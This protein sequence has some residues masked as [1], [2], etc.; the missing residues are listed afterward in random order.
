MTIK[1]AQKLYKEGCG[2]FIVLQDVHG[3]ELLF[4]DGNKT[5]ILKSYHKAKAALREKARICTGGKYE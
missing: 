5:H 2:D 3:S 4:S 1:E